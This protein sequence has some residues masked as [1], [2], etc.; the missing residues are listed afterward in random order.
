MTL[1]LNRLIELP[2]IFLSSMGIIQLVTVLTGG[3][4]ANQLVKIKTV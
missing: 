4:I 3:L 1:I 2:S